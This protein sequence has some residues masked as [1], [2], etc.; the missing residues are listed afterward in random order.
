MNGKVVL[1]TG[2]TAG[3]GSKFKL[4][5]ITYV[6]AFILYYKNAFFVKGKLVRGSL[7]NP[8]RS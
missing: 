4:R 7:Q 6:F 8:E 1:I 2:A 3:I 5:K